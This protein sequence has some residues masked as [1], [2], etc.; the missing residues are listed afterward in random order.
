[1]SGVYSLICTKFSAIVECIPIRVLALVGTAYLVF[2]LPLPLVQWVVG[3]EI[4]EILVLALK[5]G[6]L[7]VPT[8]W[9][10]FVLLLVSYPDQ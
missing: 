1:M 10:S 3:V 8:D 2:M 7:I 9:L 6:C 5:E 4:L